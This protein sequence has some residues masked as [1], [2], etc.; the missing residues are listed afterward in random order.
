MVYAVV[1]FQ[2]SDETDY[3]PF[4]WIANLDCTELPNVEIE[5]TIKER[6]E[7][8]VYWPPTNIPSAIY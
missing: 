6:K 1:A 5:T 3:V 2:N 8:L 7:V 4:K